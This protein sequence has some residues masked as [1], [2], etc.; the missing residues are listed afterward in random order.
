MRAIRTFVAAL[1]VTAA[2]AAQS[3]VVVASFDPAVG[4][5]MPN[6]GYRGTAQLFIDDS[7]FALTGTVLNSNACSLNTMVVQTATVEFYDLSNPIP[8]ILSTTFGPND[9][10][11]L[12]AT[13]SGGE[14]IGFD[15]TFSILNDIVLTQGVNG[16]PIDFSGAV[17]IRFFGGAEPNAE[18]NVCSPQDVRGQ[19]EC[20][21]SNPATNFTFTRLTVPEPGSVALVLLAAGL[22][23][24]AARRR[25]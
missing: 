19:R 21:T 16:S 12:S 24:G 4:P 7:C 2:T 14:L 3:A 6:V 11:V 18:L 9:P 8:T 23:A 15:T 25:A 17:A 5:A 1:A 22:A 10:T 13:F 20:Q